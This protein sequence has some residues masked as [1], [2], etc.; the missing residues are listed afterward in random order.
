MSELIGTTPRDVAADFRSDSTH[1]KSFFP[2]GTCQELVIDKKVQTVWVPGRSLADLK[3]VRQE[4][5]ETRPEA[6]EPLAFPF[7]EG[8]VAPPADP[9]ELSA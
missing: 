5:L 3:L 8:I 9:I 1:I 4:Y 6:R 7:S 2:D